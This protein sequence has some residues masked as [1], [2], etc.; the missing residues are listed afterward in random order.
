MNYRVAYPSYKN[1]ILNSVNAVRDYLNLP[2]YHDLDQDVSLWLKEHQFKQLIILLID[3]MG[4]SLVDQNCEVNGFF[5]TYCKKK[6][7]TVYPPTTSAAT[8]SVLTGKAPIETAWFGW[9]QYFK[10]ID[11]HLIM[12]LNRRYYE[13]SFYPNTHYTYQRVP[14]VNMID[15][16]NQNN[17]KALEVFPAFRANGVHSFTEMVDRLIQYSQSQEYEFIYGY[18]DGY[19]SAMHQMG[20]SSKRCHAIINSMD[21]LCERFK[22]EL[23]SQTGLIILADHGHMD[24][25]FKNLADYPELVNCFEKLPALETR[26]I[27]FM[28]KPEKKA[29]FSKLFQ[30][31]FKDTFILYTKKEALDS[32]LFGMGKIHP[33]ADD[34]LGDFI[35]CAI[36]DLCLY[37]SDNEN[38]EVVFKGNHAGMCDIEMKIPLILYP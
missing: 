34:F 32:H 28:I 23:D 37:Y 14:I 18:W 2:V 33:Q 36:S 20:A 5:K 8:T 6:I 24:V 25:H 12:F 17:R 29:L 11:E 30:A 15:E 16:L 1:C 3:G 21:K 22:S 31:Q 9:Q 4:Y 35:A 10:E 38:E 26:T 13:N 7:E 19:D 27:S